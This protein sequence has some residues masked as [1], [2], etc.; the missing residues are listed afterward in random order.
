MG[1]GLKNK[2]WLH[3]YRIAI[4]Y[5][6]CRYWFGSIHLYVCFESV[7]CL[8]ELVGYCSRQEKCESLSHRY[9][10]LGGLREQEK[11]STK[12]LGNRFGLCF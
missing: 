10:Y 6:I 4:A 2:F 3:S 7:V 9:R 1:K 5:G 8:C 11:T 12:T